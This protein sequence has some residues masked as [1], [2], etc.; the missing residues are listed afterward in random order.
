MVGGTLVIAGDG[1]ERQRLEAMAVPGVIFTGRVSEEEK[2]RLLCA[3]WLL[4]HPA[5]RAPPT[6][7][8]ATT[9]RDERWNISATSR[10]AKRN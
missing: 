7:R 5:M 6:A 9:A 10:G 2:H 1:P 3:A 4:L 8:T